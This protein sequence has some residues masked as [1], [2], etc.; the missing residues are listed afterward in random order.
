MP[1]K[2]PHPGMSNAG[3]ARSAEGRPTRL[4]PPGPLAP[5]RR[6]TLRGRVARLDASMVRMRARLVRNRRAVAIGLLC[7]VA[8]IG[9][10]ALGTDGEDGSG[11]SPGGSETPLRA[12]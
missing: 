7:V 11:G 3:G 12:R 1:G 5:R 6:R 8:A 4:P 9:L 2:G 10:V